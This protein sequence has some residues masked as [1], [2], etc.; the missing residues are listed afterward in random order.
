MLPGAF[1]SIGESPEKGSKLEIIRG[2]QG[3][4]KTKETDLNF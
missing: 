4:L 1:R 3:K 2:L